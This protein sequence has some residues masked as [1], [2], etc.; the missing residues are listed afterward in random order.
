MAAPRPHHPQRAAGLVLTGGGARAAYQVGVLEAISDLRKA[1]GAGRDPNPFPIITGTSAGAINA[2]AL[3]CGADHFDRAVRRIAHV[4]RDFHAPQVYRA[5]SLSV[6]RSGARWLTLLSLGWAV[7]RWR[8][9][10]PRSLLDNAPLSELLAR[11]VPLSRLPR[12]IRDGHLQALAVTAS[13]YSSGEHITF[14]EAAEALQPWARQQRRA[15]RGRITHPHLL[16]S[17][18]IPFV[19]PA[20]ALEIGGR[21]EFFGDGSMR[22]SAPIAPAIHLGAERVL[23]IGAGRMHEPAGDAAAEPAPAYPSLA[24]VAGHALSNIFLDALAVDVERAQR[25]NQTLALIPPEAR[26]NSPLRPLE[27]LVIAPSQRLDALAARHVADLPAPVRTLLGA[28]GVTT[29]ARD[30]RGAALASYLL[31]EPGYTRE[32]MALGRADALARRGEICRFFG[33]RDAGHALR[34]PTQ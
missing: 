26:A 33:W 13:S 9:M 27:L 10:R 3:A 30:V 17:S 19:F 8:R 6:M 24:Q 4:W 31:F 21:T 29:N 1:C 20:T 2:A 34:A 5:D 18:A 28:L 14:F 23:V 32:L 11:L 7:A 16:A 25:I 12:L 22:Q 15:S